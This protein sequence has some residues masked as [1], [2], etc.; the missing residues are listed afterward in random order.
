M[1][2]VMA[3]LVVAVSMISPR[4][5]GFI[6]GRALES[7]ARRLLAVTHAA[8]SRAISESLPVLV[9]LDASTGRYGIELENRGQNGDPQSQEFTVDEHLRIAFEQAQR[10][11]GQT[12]T[13]TRAPTLIPGFS[14]TQR[15]VGART[16]P[17]IRLHPDGTIDEDSPNAIRIEDA[18]G[19]VL[20]LVEGSDR[21]H[22]EIRSTLQ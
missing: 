16:E 14:N 17:S 1:I 4:L 7:E 21:R 5:S 20:W 10:L 22:Y 3:L 12:P 11:I 8:R 13:G 9:W 6:R 18:D 15:P 2:L 19:A